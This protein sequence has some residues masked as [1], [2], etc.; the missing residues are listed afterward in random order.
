MKPK[1]LIVDDQAISRALVARGLARHGLTED[2]DV[3]QAENGAVGLKLFEAHIDIRQMI[4]DV[5]MPVMDGPTM[6]RMMSVRWPDRIASTTIYMVT[7][8]ENESLRA[9]C[10]S[11]GVD[12][13]LLK[14][15]DITKF[16]G[17]IRQHAA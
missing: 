3:L 17:H 7:T 8:E 16:C 2:Y 15:L 10:L 1:I 13:W 6:L 4:V 11:Y 9:R 5:H 12:E 14:P